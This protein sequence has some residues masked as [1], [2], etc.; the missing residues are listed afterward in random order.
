M[1][2]RARPTV[3]QIG[4]GGGGGYGNTGGSGIRVCCCT[5]CTCIHFKFLKTAP[6]VLK[7]MEIVS[8]NF[9]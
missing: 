6:G 2:G 9:I 1:A 4:G 5:C 8:T 7:F 3:V